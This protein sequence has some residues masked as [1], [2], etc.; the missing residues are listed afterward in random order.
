MV[1][2]TIRS[3]VEVVNVDKSA[4]KLTIKTPSGEMDTLDIKDSGMQSDLDKIKKGDKI[5]AS[6]TEAVAIAVTP[7]GKQPT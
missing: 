6:Y 4:N 3:T 7:Q 1:A 5:K 2:H